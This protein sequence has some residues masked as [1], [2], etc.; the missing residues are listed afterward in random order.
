MENVKNVGEKYDIVEVAPGYAHNFLFPKKLAKLANSA[1]LK[2]LESKRKDW[3]KK[4]RKELKGLEKE[5]NKIKGTEIVIK[6]RV[7]E[8]GRLFGS[9]DAKQIKE[10]L[11]EK[12]FD[13]KKGEI[14]LKEP[15]KET[16]EWTITISFPHNLEVEIKLVVEKVEEDE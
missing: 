8:E 11:E 4:S 13:I 3:Q 7:N 16:G 2:E 10:S 6:K 9:V 1:N 15:I 14:V 5:I 12:G